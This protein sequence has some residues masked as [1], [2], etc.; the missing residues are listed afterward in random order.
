MNITAGGEYK[1]SPGLCV[2]LGGQRSA[3]WKPV[4]TAYAIIIII[5]IIIIITIA[6]CFLVFRVP[7]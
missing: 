5:I 1:F 6:C 4:L 7:G 2:W 3:V